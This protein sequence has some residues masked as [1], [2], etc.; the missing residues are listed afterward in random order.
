[1]LF[2]YHA[3]MCV[4]CWRSAWVCS[5][6]RR[7]SESSTDTQK[8]KGKGKERGKE[9]EKRKEKDTDEDSW[10]YRSRRRWPSLGRIQIFTKMDKIVSRWAAGM[11]CTFFSLSPRVSGVFSCVS[12]YHPFPPS[13]STC[14]IFH[15]P[16][17]HT[18]TSRTIYACYN[19]PYVRREPTMVTTH[20]NA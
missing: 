4:G 14:P 7:R 5:A 8:G 20:T 10:R 12:D 15:L 1:M 19:L 17:G 2:L 11:A 3:C 9:K 18:H 6:C 16:L 13:L